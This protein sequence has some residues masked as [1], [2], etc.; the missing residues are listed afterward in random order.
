MKQGRKLTRTEKEILRKNK[1]NADEYQFLADVI[2]PDGR[3]TSSF[4]IQHKQTGAIRIISR[5]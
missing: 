3:P 5:I 2:M 4:K 1:L